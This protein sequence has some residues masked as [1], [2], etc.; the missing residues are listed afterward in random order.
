LAPTPVTGLKH[1]N[2]QLFLFL[3]KRNLEMKSK[4]T[5]VLLASSLALAC[6]TPALASNTTITID[7]NIEEVVVL[8]VET[9][10]GNDTIVSPDD[11][12]PQP[13]SPGAD[14]VLDFGTVDPY[15]INNDGSTSNNGI[16]PGVAPEKQ[17]YVGNTVYDEGGNSTSVASSDVEGALYFIQGGYQVRALRSGQLDTEVDVGVDGTTPLPALVALNGTNDYSDGMTISGR[18]DPDITDPA[19][20]NYAYGDPTYS[21][22]Y[23][24]FTTLQHNV[25]KTIDVGIYVPVSHAPGSTSTTITFYGT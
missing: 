15:A 6:L 18:V 4:L 9:A 24:P 11:L 17:L 21:Y 2:L 1:A 14:D 13:G 22:A 20:P 7:A 23:T 5:K 19:D 25:P 3:R 16:D 10:D 12:D 8:Q